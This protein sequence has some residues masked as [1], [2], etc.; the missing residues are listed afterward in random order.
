MQSNKHLSHLCTRLKIDDFNHFTFVWVL[1]SLALEEWISAERGIQI[2]ISQEGAKD[3]NKQ[4][5]KWEM[6]RI[7]EQRLT[8]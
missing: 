2:L 8:I 1:Q 5:L 4:T 3:N 6:I 7:P